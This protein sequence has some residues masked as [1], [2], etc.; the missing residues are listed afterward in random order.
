VNFA[1]GYTGNVRDISHGVVLRSRITEMTREQRRLKTEIV[2]RERRI[3]RLEGQLVDARQGELARLDQRRQQLETQVQA[4][5][6]AIKRATERLRE[7]EQTGGRPTPKPQP[8]STS[9]PETR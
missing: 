3:K 1:V 2:S 8:P 7:L 5:R 9:P 4:E 6:E